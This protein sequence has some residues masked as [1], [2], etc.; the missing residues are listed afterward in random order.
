M[1]SLGWKGNKANAMYVGPPKGGIRGHI[2]FGLSA[3]ETGGLSVSAV[4]TVGLIYDEFRAFQWKWFPVKPRYS[5]QVQRHPYQVLE[6]AAP[7]GAL[8]SFDERG[9]DALVD[10]CIDAVT[11]MRAHFPTLRA[12]L[13]C[14]PQWETEESVAG[15]YQDRLILGAAFVGEH[16]KARRL[17]DSARRFWRRRAE[18]T[19]QDVSRPLASLDTCE[20]A[21]E[22]GVSTSDSRLSS[23]YTRYSPRSRKS[24]STLPPGPRAID[25]IPAPSA[26]PS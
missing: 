5:P 21:I 7:R 1:T 22:S 11:A 4:P 14:S 25:L 12:A 24:I 13:A 20:R 3:L 19:G 23:G 15:G 16:D 26:P 6:G 2:R 18:E 10:E 8:R 9:L 17:L